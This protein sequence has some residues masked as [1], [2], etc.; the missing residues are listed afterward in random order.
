MTFATD[1]SRWFLGY[2]GACSRAS[3][4]FN[5]YK[6]MSSDMYHELYIH[7]S[8]RTKESECLL[9]TTS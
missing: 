1:F 3:A 8:W 6:R 7:L 9:S 4:G 2:G 5:R